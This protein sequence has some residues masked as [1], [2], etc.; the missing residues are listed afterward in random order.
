MFNIVSVITFRRHHNTSYFN[1][2]T[3]L[4]HT[5]A[6]HFSPTAPPQSHKHT[7]T[8]C[9]VHHILFFYFSFFSAIYFLLFFF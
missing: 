1:P 8:K 9:D 2:S 3:T 4:T 6:I 5:H 7:L